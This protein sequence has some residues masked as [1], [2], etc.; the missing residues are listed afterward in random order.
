MQYVYPAKLYPDEEFIGVA[1]P[2]LPGCFTYGKD[3]ADALVMAK[4]AVEMWLTDAEDQQ[5]PIP[6]PSKTL[7]LEEG[8][9]FTLIQANTAE[10]RKAHSNQSVK[11]TL[12]IPAWL[13]FQAEKANAPFSHILQEGL[14]SYLK[15]AQ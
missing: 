1:V 4:D 3:T 5:E 10:Y 2:D 7:V 11:K 13:N 6:T 12:T 9:I 8:E 15:I 14:K